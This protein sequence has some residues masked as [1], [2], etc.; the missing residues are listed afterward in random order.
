MPWGSEEEKER[1]ER[2]A[3]IVTHAVVPP[4]L[5]LET[6]TG[7]LAGAQAVVGVDTGLTHLAGAV[8]APTVGVYTATDPAATG[9]FRCARGAN[10]GGIGAQPGVA[11][12]TAA[13]DKVLG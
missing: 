13:L 12:V 4:A 5:S 6:L 1:S 9:L 10:V 8:G 3:E 7:L 11:E 2:I